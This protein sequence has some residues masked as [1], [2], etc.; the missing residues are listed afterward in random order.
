MLCGCES[1]SGAGGVA[2][3]VKVEMVHRRFG[4][5]EEGVDGAGCQGFSSSTLTSATAVSLPNP[6]RVH[7]RYSRAEILAAF[8]VHDD[9][10][11]P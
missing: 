6:L 5:T 7:G 2:V 8:A 9:R 10:G 3:V 1:P 11:A 4:K